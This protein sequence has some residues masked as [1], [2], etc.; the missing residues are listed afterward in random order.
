MN[1]NRD[2]YKKA[3]DKVRSQRGDSVTPAHATVECPRCGTK[4]VLTDKPGMRYCLNC[5]FEFRR[6][7]S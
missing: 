1:Q 7:G 6:L 3:I 5:G 2:A 4:Q